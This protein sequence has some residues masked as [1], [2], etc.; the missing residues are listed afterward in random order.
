MCFAGLAQGVCDELRERA[1]AWNA[2]LERLRRRA[3][4]LACTDVGALVEAAALEVARG[5]LEEAAVAAREAATLDLL[6][7]LELEEAAK[8]VGRAADATM[9]VACACWGRGRSP[10]STWG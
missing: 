4:D 10:C 1:A 7:E 2:D 6:R 3:A 5:Q 9:L 8:K